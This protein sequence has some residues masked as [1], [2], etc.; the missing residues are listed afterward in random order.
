MALLNTRGTRD[1][2]L[3][4]YVALPADG[5]SA[6]SPSLDL[7]TTAAGAAPRVSL[8]FYTPAM[9]TLASGKNITFVVQDSADNA[10]FANVTGIASY[11]VTGPA[12][13]GAP[14][15]TQSPNAKLPSTLRRYI[16]FVATADAGAGG[17]T[18]VTAR[19]S[20]LC[21]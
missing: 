1:I 19:L 12:S 20:V 10:T 9:P 16:R 14:V 2:N 13:G 15:T 7:G 21:G 4:I 5:A 3:E 8:Q 6:T 18:A 11:A 17:V